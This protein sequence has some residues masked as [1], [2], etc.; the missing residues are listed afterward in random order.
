M[1]LCST[2]GLH[3][4][5]TPIYS[6]IHYSYIHYNHFTIGLTNFI[7]AREVRVIPTLR[8]FHSPP[9]FLLH[10]SEESRLRSHLLSASADQPS[11]GLRFAAETP[12]P[13]FLSSLSSHVTQVY[14]VNRRVEFFFPLHRPTI[15]FCHLLA[16]G[17]QCQALKKIL[18]SQN[19]KKKVALGDTATLNLVHCSVLRA[20]HTN[21]ALA[22]LFDK[23]HTR[24]WSRTS[25]APL[26]NH[27]DT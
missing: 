3:V 25:G 13:P 19:N 18:Y 17:L 27:A 6:Y 23:T 22:S 11:G 24:K 20:R 7:A 15:Y 10:P 8:E 4:P 21:F 9:S 12:S 16:R 26:K 14:C 1:I 5:F 2:S